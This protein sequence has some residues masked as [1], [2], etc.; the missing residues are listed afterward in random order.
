MIRWFVKRLQPHDIQYQETFW[1]SPICR[2]IWML[3]WLSSIEIWESISR[4]TFKHFWNLLSKGRWPSSYSIIW[5]LTFQI[6]PQQRQAC[7]QIGKRFAKLKKSSHSVE[8]HKTSFPWDINRI[9]S[10]L[11]HIFLIIEQYETKRAFDMLRMP[12]PSRE[13]RSGELL[14]AQEINTWLF[15]AQQT[16]ARSRFLLMFSFFRLL[17]PLMAFFRDEI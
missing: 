13:E 1:Y 17:A 3:F 14:F 10:D 7:W 16:P 12:S 8:A 5:I 11:K 15:E 4:L 9:A 6:L 2:H